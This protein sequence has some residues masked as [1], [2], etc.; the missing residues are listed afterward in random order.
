MLLKYYC[1]YLLKTGVKEFTTTTTDSFLFSF[2]F[3]RLNSSENFTDC[4]ISSA[5]IHFLEMYK[6]V[7]CIVP[8]IHS[9]L[10]SFHHF[11]KETLS[12]SA[13]LSSS[14]LSY[15]WELL[16]FSSCPWIC[17]F[18]SHLAHDSSFKLLTLDNSSWV[19]MCAE[20]GTTFFPLSA[21]SK[22]G[23]VCSLDWPKT[24]YIVQHA[25][26]L[27]HTSSSALLSTGLQAWAYPIWQ[28]H[29]LLLPDNIYS[30]NSFHFAHPFI[31]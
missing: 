30:M 4:I 10:D 31:S 5:Q 25:A 9:N 19:F 12:P 13:V 28:L 21:V 24:H 26:N 8:L 20:T 2:G 18:W 29:F 11:P 22:M 7:P 3:L 23:F 16:L 6:V 14:L 1:L 15:L 17:I 27:Q